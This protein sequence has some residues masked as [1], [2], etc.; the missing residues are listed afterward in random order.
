MSLTKED[1][2]KLISEYRTHDRDS[3]SP[4]VQIALLTADILR[5]TEHMQRHRK[6]HHSRQGLMKKVHR[7]NKLLGYLNRNEHARYLKVVERLG[8]RR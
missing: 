2:S 8:L 7:R 3:G 4:E 1:R 5:L 6:D